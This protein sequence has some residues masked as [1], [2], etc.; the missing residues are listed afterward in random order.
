LYASPSRR[1]TL[2]S[3]A[4][5]KN[6]C[7]DKAP[8]EI[9][10]LSDKLPENHPLKAVLLQAGI[11]SMTRFAL[12]AGGELIGQ[13]LL[14]DLPEV[15][16]VAEINQIINLLAPPIALAL[17]NA[18]AF[19]QIEQQAQELEQRVVERTAELVQKSIDFQ[20]SEAKFRSYIDSSPD[21]IFVADRVGRF[22]EVNKSATA[23]TGYFESELLKMSVTEVLHPES[24]ALALLDFQSLKDTGSSS[25][26]YIFLHKNGSKRWLSIDAVKLSG[27]RYLSF[28]KDITDR[29]KTE[30]ERRKLEAQLH[31]SQK[32]ESVGRLAGGV[33]HDFNNM[34]GVI[35][36]HAELLLMQM[37]ASHP[38]YADLAAIRTAS[39][40][41]ADL[42]RQLLAFARKQAVAP[43]EI[44]L[45]QTLSGMFKMLQRLIGEDIHL[46][47]HPAEN[48]WQVK[49]DSSQI[50]QIL[51]NLCVN[52]RDAIDGIGRIT[53]ETGNSSI[54]SSYCTGNPDAAPGEY[55]RLSVSDNGSGMDKETLSHIFEPFYTTKDQG[56]G[57]GLGLATVYGAVK[58]NRGFI[59]VYSEPGTGTTFTIYLPRHEGQAG[60]VR[61]ED[62]ANTE[63]LGQETVLLVED[64]PA[65]L[66]MVKLI[67]SSH[68]YLVVDASAPGEA[69]RLAHEYS[70]DIHLL[71]TDVIMPEMN[72]RDLAKNLLS[73]Y[74]H[75]K[76]L[77]MSGYTSDVIAH[78]GVLEEGVN[79]IQKPFTVQDLT[80]KLRDV[81]DSK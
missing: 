10:F 60:Q 81:L 8:G 80:A 30:E 29:K 5:L 24:L 57:T 78:H 3:A 37:D 55:V 32:M 53:I 17:K 28:S 43:R 11:Q 27:T 51:A 23:I 36:G 58:Q 12:R 65:I 31:Q 71:M 66:N 46:D 79:F 44:D 15:G 48:L 22:I 6:F 16:R 59:N 74:P 69:I 76:R 1:S 26:E 61:R 9:P 54:D 50:D 70:G 40:R 34:L 41:S 47:W 35:L 38:F 67:L 20:K 75:M 73:I 19:Q 68:G 72:G 25:G 77:F 21:G 64:E 33:A 49:M 52:A 42:T 56:K 13:L 4:E 14:F 63:S 2:F 7:F 45:N 39:Q 18:L 62:S